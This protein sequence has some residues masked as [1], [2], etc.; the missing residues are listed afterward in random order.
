MDWAATFTI[1]LSGHW[2]FRS[3]FVYL[4]VC[5]DMEQFGGNTGGKTKTKRKSLKLL[6]LTRFFSAAKRE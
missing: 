5:G 1:R 4:E 2:Q 6:Q 3:N